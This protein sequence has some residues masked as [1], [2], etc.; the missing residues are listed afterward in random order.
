MKPRE[1]NTRKKRACKAD[2]RVHSKESVAQPVT[3]YH[4][5]GSK[6]ID[7]G[8]SVAQP[9]T[10]ER[11]K[12]TPVLTEPAQE[13]FWLPAGVRVPGGSPFSQ[14]QLHEK[15]N[16]T[17]VKNNKNLHNHWPEQ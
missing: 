6:R 8:E 14:L 3:P 2:L 11:L 12:A 7:E 5:S 15:D 13:F 1:T 10:P 9:V 4:H 16:S 17:F